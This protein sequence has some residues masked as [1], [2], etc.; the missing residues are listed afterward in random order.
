MGTDHQRSDGLKDEG[1]D[2]RT[3]VKIR[4]RFTKAIFELDC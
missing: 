4:T 2:F 1:K 3:F